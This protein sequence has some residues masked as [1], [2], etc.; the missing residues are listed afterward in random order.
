MKY[1]LIPVFIFISFYQASAYSAGSTYYYFP[2]NPNLKWTYGMESF[3]VDSVPVIIGGVRTRVIRDHLGGGEYYSND[4]DGLR[5]HRIDEDFYGTQDLI[6]QP[7]IVV[8]GTQL[9]PG[10]SRISTGQVTIKI[11]GVGNFNF[12]Y[13]AN[14]TVI[15]SE[16]ISTPAGQYDTNKIDFSFTISGIVNGASISETAVEAIWLAKDIG[17]VKWEVNDLDNQQSTMTLSDFTYP[18]YDNSPIFWRHSELGTLWRYKLLVH[19]R[20]ASVSV[21]NSQG[22]TTVADLDWKVAGTADFDGD[23]RLDILWRHSTTGVNWL[24]LLRDSY[25]LESLF[26]NHLQDQNWKV[27]GTGD[28]DGDR[29]ADIL[30]RNVSTG[31]NWLYFMDGNKVRLSLP[32]N[33]IAD[34]NWKIAGTADFDGDGKTDILWRNVSTGL[35][36]IYLMDGATV[37]LS[38]ALDRVADLSWEIATIG[39]FDGDGKADIFWRHQLSGIN[40][41][42]LMD[43][44]SIKN[45]QYVNV[46]A[47]PDWKVAAVGS[48]DEWDLQ[49]RDV[50]DGKDDI[51]WHNRTTGSNIL[52]IM[53][54]ASLQYTRYIN[55]LSDLKWKAVNK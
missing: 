16:V 49:G 20:S 44:T 34:Q 46:L 36:W 32:V 7:P 30:W 12:D 51:L 50:K 5:L 10:Q 38:R 13:T 37:K 26:I 22:I 3:Y 47:D 9:V 8:A 41:M 40:W 6:F 52:Y 4:G 53:N 33:V 21:Q 2:L 45:N 43:G 15:G 17:P 11:A 31:L 55:T 39:D 25:I 28:F 27:V 29:K 23:G 24:Y 48:S 1:F 19:N 18:E 35:N 54:G 42:Y 14:S